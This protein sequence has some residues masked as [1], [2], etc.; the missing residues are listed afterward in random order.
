M[1]KMR[2]KTDRQIETNKEEMSINPNL[3]KFE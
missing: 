1:R 3:G 2:N